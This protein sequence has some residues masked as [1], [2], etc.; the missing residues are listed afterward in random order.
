MSLIN[1]VQMG[2]PVRPEIMTAQLALIE[3]IAQRWKER[4]ADT[5]FQDELDAALDNDRAMLFAQFIN[6][7]KVVTSSAATLVEV[8]S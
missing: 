5:A 2:W 8:I 6:E 3:G 7:L 4:F 1:S